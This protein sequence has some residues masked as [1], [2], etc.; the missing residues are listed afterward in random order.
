MMKNP[1]FYF[2]I[3]LGV[4]LVSV[5]LTADGFLGNLQERAMNK[6]NVTRNELV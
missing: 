2:L 3:H 5:A 4:L 6:H 1:L